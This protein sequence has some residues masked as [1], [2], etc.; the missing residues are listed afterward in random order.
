MKKRLVLAC[1]LAAASPVAGSAAEPGFKVLFDGTSTDAWRGFRRDA[2]PSKGWVVENGALK[3]VVGGDRCD[4]F[5]KDTYKDFELELEWKVSPGGNS[6]VFYGVS[7]SEKETYFTGPEMQVLDDAGHND[8]KDPKTSAGSLYALVAP[9]GK[10]LKPV[11]EYNQTRLVKKGSHVEHWLN[12]KKVVEYELGSEALAKLI[13]ESKFKDMTRFAKEGQGHIALQH[14]GQEVWY[15]NV[16]IRP[17]GASAD[18]A[19]PNT[20]SAAEKKAGWRLLFDGKTSN[21]WRGFKGKE[22]PG[23]VW[24]VEDGTLKRPAKQGSHGGA[25]IITVDSFDDFDLRFEWRISPAGNSGVKYL[26]TEE[27]SGP[28]AHEY[29][30]ID[31]D[32]H[33]DALIGDHRKTAALY[34]ALPATGT[35]L[36]K[37]GE[38]NASRIFVRGRH[39][40]HWLNGKKVLEYELEGDALRAAKARSKFKDEPGWGTKLKGHIL[41]QDHGDEVA[42]RNIKILTGASE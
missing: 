22:F 27:R 24:V 12:G 19:P 11:G 41:L 35:A 32:K 1:A 3:T 28:I 36:R 2:F 34:D 4:L 8:G 37:V 20:L 33:P 21:G 31:D 7:E 25:D 16:R 39:V 40:E 26:V 42:F 23:T 38:F 18:G 30:L 13:A 14:H 5:T 29:Q 9:V 10:T 15:R 6:G 17:L